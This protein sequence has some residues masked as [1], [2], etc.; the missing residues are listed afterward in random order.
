MEVG[1]KTY[2]NGNK[3]AE[4]QLRTTQA[5]RDIIPIHHL[6]LALVRPKDDELAAPPP[7]GVPNAH[8]HYRIRHDHLHHVRVLY[9]SF[10]LIEQYICTLVPISRPCQHCHPSFSLNLCRVPYVFF[11]EERSYEPTTRRPYTTGGAGTGT[12]TCRDSACSG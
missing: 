9:Y 5:T 12:G 8:H 1:N 3:N 10:S 7:A 4:R 11:A 6:A 2:G